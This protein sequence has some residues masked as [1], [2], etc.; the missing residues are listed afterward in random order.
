VVDESRYILRN[1]H[2]TLEDARNAYLNI[3]LI[4]SVD[5]LRTCLTYVEVLC[6]E[7]AILA[8]S[9]KTK[10]D[11][12]KS[13]VRGFDND[14]PR[15]FGA[16]VFCLAHLSDVGPT[17]FVLGSKSVPDLT[18]LEATVARAT[19]F[20]K[21][22]DPLSLAT[23]PGRTS[24]ATSCLSVFKQFN[25]LRRLV[26]HTE[27]DEQFIAHRLR[28]RSWLDFVV[29]GISGWPEWLASTAFAAVSSFRLFKLASQDLTS[30]KYK[31]KGELVELQTSSVEGDVRATSTNYDWYLEYSDNK[32]K[33]AFP[34][35]E[36]GKDVEAFL[37]RCRPRVR[38]SSMFAS[39]TKGCLAVV[40]AGLLT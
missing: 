22:G 6:R 18:P 21:T 16:D 38:Q 11:L 19:S 1:A 24:E 33:R 34:R 28:D 36:S 15:S 20:L 7:L 35:I 8:M 5:D 30:V 3:E 29:R 26:S 14:K 10:G 13:F 2:F 40:I 17:R 23:P 25:L 12:S 31:R 32:P 37:A 39:A 9:A 27:K 4:D